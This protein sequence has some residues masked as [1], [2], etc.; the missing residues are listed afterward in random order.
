MRDLLSI[1]LAGLASLETIIPQARDPLVLQV[2]IYYIAT[3]TTTKLHENTK[4][5]QV[6]FITV[7]QLSNTKCTNK[8][9]FAWVRVNATVVVVTGGNAG[10]CRSVVLPSLSLRVMVMATVVVVVVVVGHCRCHWEREAKTELRCN[11]RREC[12]NRRPNCVAMANR[13]LQR[14]QATRT[15]EIAT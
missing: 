10:G 6:L 13:A 11:G 5:I 9:K 15:R 3:P 1:L 12:W 8:F 14:E 4:E 2:L 7:S